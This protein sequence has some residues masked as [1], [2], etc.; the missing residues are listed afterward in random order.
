MTAAAKAAAAA[1]DYDN[2]D[3]NNYSSKININM[4]NRFG[5]CCCRAIVSSLTFIVKFTSVI[6]SSQHPLPY[7]VAVHNSSNWN[8][9]SHRIQLQFK[10]QSIISTIVFYVN[11]FLLSLL[12]LLLLLLLSVFN[13]P[14][15]YSVMMKFLVQ[16]VFT[17]G[18]VRLT[19]DMRCCLLHIRFFFCI[20]SQIICWIG[21]QSLCGIWMNQCINLTSVKWKIEVKM[22][23]FSF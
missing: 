7:T 17:I 18:F 2:N 8:S 3:N 11:S 16:M 14:P 22:Y 5:H 21:I 19:L 10:I 13:F 4:P 20:A 6:I 12:L 23:I 15:S 9:K 1:A